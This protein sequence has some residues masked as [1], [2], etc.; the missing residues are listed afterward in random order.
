MKILF[1]IKSSEILNKKIRQLIRNT[2]YAAN[3]RTIFTSRQLLTPVGKD[4]IS[5]LNKSMYLTNTAAIAI[6]AM[7]D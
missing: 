2:Y 5:N 4:L 6:Q 3:P 1:F 7:L